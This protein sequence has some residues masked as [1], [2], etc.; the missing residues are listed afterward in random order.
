MIMTVD[1]HHCP[2]LSEAMPKL[3]VKL[4]SIIQNVHKVCNCLA[5]DE[6]NSKH[7]VIVTLH[8]NIVIPWLHDNDRTHTRDNI[9]FKSPH[10]SETEHKI[11]CGTYLW[12]LFGGLYF[13]KQEASDD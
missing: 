13:H 5:G 8:F 11:F 1:A 4:R 9:Y 10:I 7:N 12:H 3:I 2:F 6:E